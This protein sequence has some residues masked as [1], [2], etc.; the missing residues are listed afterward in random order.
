MQCAEE[1]EDLAGFLK[2]TH[3]VFTAWHHDIT[4]EVDHRRG[5]GLPVA[6]PEESKTVATSLSSQESRQQILV[7]WSRR[8]LAY[9]RQPFEDTRTRSRHPS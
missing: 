3:V 4:V 5:F 7:A 8:P 2:Y 6:I 9:I 1:C